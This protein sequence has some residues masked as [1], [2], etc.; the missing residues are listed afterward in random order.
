MTY[1]IPIDSKEVDS[2]MVVESGRKWSSSTVVAMGKVA[3]FR[4]ASGIKG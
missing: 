2:R 1:E 3:V 4:S